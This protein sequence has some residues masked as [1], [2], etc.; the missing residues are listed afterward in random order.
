MLYKEKL[1][2]SK[3]YLIHNCVYPDIIRYG[4]HDT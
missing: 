2:K 3:T 1:I 4:F